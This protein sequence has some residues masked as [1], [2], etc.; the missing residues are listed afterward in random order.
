MRRG[1][2][3]RCLAGGVALAVT[4]AMLAVA[5]AC[6]S[7]TTATPAATATPSLT[8]TATASP[9]ETPVSTGG[10]TTTPTG[11]QYKDELAGTGPR[12]KTGDCIAV[13][14]TGK[15]EDGTVFDSS[16]GG[17]PI[18]F[19]LG[20]GNVIQ[21]W[22]E[23]LSSMQVGGKRTLVIP[24]DLGYGPTGRPPVIPPNA[25]LVFD[26]ELVAIRGAAACQ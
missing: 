19:V 20:V 14:Y 6:G 9:Q 12:P 22:D 24:P 17:R 7:D 1:V 4:G 5:A 23:G 15:L 16:A 18:I 2:I 10:F 11:L 25:T 3:A 21:G 8:P 26:V 13:H